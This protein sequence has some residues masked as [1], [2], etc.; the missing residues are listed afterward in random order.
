MTAANITGSQGWKLRHGA[1]GAHLFHRM[2]GLNILLDELKVP[3]SA[4]SLAPR[5]IS[6]ALTNACDLSCGHCYAPK[7]RASLHI[8]DL[9]TW[10][11]ELD[12][13]GSLGVGFGG[14]E[15]MLF[16]H[17]ADVCRFATLNTQLAITFTT[18]GH[19][20]DEHLARDLAG[21]VHFIRVSMDGV[22]PT[23]ERVRGRSFSDF[24]DRL[25]TIRGISKFGINFVVTAQTFPDLDA[26]VAIAADGGA[27]EFL[28]L[29]E[30]PTSTSLGID[31]ST[32]AAL[33][34][35][36]LGYRGPL[37]LLISEAA[38]E[39]ISYCT[40]VPDEDALDA[41]AHIDAAGVLKPTSFQVEGVRIGSDGVI[42]A[43]ARLRRIHQENTTCDSGS[44]TALSIQPTWS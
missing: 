27:S 6:I 30:R 29:P 15:P 36:V 1:G 38:A 19:H 7:T 24:L 2:S 33:R 34:S 20:V 28:L 43:L 26:A 40:P 4:W 10:L 11:V 44:A 21:N 5:Q 8:E 39:G 18:H 22:G 3:Q 37:P 14:G 13:N 31:Q 32:A 42:A 16:P 25:R 23:Y 41:Y 12:R 9:T 17:F 35:W